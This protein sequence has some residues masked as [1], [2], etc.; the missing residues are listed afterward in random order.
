[1][2]S[3]SKRGRK[4]KRSLAFTGKGAGE[5]VR[6]ARTPYGR[7]AEDL[8]A[9]RQDAPRKIM[10]SGQTELGEHQTLAMAEVW[11]T[12]VDTNQGPRGQY[13]RKGVL[14]TMME[15]AGCSGKEAE[16]PLRS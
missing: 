14:P 1:M 9:A 10:V 4:R 11:P 6:A 7:H 13:D 12:T 15:N 8:G 3:S 16:L 5:K 2:T